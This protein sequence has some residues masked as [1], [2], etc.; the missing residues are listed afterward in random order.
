M[1]KIEDYSSDIAIIIK[2][3][4]KEGLIKEAI[5]AC[6]EYLLGKKPMLGKEKKVI[7]F[8]IKGNLEDGIVDALN[9]F[10]KTFYIEKYV[11]YRIYV[12]E[13]KEKNFEIKAFARLFN[14][15]LIHYI[16]AA[17]YQDNKIVQKGDMFTLKVVFDV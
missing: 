16:K 15:N 14:G 6:F 2:S 1:R 4:T 5:Y 8:E 13:T 12:K 9:F 3:K 11:P 17:T 10:L 7:F